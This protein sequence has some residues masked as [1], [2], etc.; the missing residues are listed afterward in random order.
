MNEQEKLEVIEAKAFK[1]GRD[2]ASLEAVEAL[3]EYL[4]IYRLKIEHWQSAWF[5]TDANAKTTAY[6]MPL[7]GAIR[8]A[9]KLC[10]LK[11]TP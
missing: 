8:H 6:G 9:M 5:V 3:N 10:V 4:S 1:D 11:R 2:N 7:G